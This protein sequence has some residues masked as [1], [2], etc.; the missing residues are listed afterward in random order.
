MGDS[1]IFNGTYL[2]EKNV[3]EK[4]YSTLKLKLKSNTY[5]RKLNRWSNWQNSE[6]DKRQLRDLEKCISRKEG[7]I[8]LEENK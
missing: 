8:H 3:F 4:R 6:K 7:Q 2:I 5:Y 1:N